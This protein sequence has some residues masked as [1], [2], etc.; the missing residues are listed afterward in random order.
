MNKII[1]YGFFLNLLFNKMENGKYY[2]LDKK[3]KRTV[4]KSYGDISAMSPHPSHLPWFDKISSNKKIYNL[5]YGN[6]KEVTDTETEN[7]IYYDFSRFHDCN[8]K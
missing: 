2:R 8:N 5:S 6:K 4:P 7:P 1:R 3:S